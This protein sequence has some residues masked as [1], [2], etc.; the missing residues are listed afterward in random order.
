LK[1]PTF[2]VEDSPVVLQSLSEALEE[3]GSVRV[4]GSA[5]SAFEASTWLRANPCAWHVVIIELFLVGSSG[6][7]V[8]DACRG[9]QDFQRAVV[10]SN[11]ATAEVRRR[12]A[13]LGADAVFDKSTEVD[14]LMEY[15]HD[16]AVAA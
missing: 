3:L 9:R 16:R 7:E 14:E 12:C 5:S 2:I 1:L 11:Y 6:T 10:L 4:I 8:L 15:V 13:T